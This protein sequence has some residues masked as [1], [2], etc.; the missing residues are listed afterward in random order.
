MPTVF[1]SYAR[2]D[3]DQARQVERELAAMEVT[4]WRDQEQLRTGQNWPKALG[5]AIAGSDALLLLWSSRAA[6]ST[7]VELEWSTALALQKPVFPCLLENVPL[8]QSVA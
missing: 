2:E 6:E 1:L 4:V 3:L 7:F 8:S 5:E